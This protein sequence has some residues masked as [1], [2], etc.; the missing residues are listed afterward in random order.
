MATTYVPLATTTT[1]GNIATITLSSIS[2][3]Y[4]DLIL[5]G[6]G[7]NSAGGS[8][9]SIRFNGDTG[10]NYSWTDLEGDGSTAASYRQANTNLIYT[11][12]NNTSIGN[13]Q[14]NYI[15]QINNYSN[16]TTYKTVLS[17][18]NAASSNVYPGTNAGIGMWRNTNAITSITITSSGGYMVDGTTFSL[19]GIA[20]AGIIASAKATGGDIVATDGTYWYHAF[21][22]SGTFTPVAT[23][24]CDVLV[25]AGGASGSAEIGAGGGAGGVLE[26]LAQSIPASAQ[27]ITIGA[28]GASRTAAS[29]GQGNNGSNSSFASLTASVGGGGGGIANATAGSTGGSGGGGGANQSG[30]P[31]A[32]GA[33]TSG[34]GNAGGT[35]GYSTQGGLN[36]WTAGGGGGKGGTGGVGGAVNF[37]TGGAGGAGSNTWSSWVGIT[38]L[39]VSGFIA[40]GGGG[41]GMQQYGG[42]SNAPVAGPAGSGGGG[43]GAMANTYGGTS[44]LAGNGTANTG[45]GGGGGGWAQVAGG[46]ATAVS[47]QGGS[48]LVI[49]R[50]AV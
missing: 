29:S 8:G 16:T 22:A 4:T 28:G 25:V 17:R 10:N 3:A 9:W 31:Y 48:G 14:S 50:Y 18:T 46:T 30:G 13:S 34:Q 35:G 5:I 47:G 26:Y 7:R 41:I 2:S 12:Y 23:L 32:G 44:S 43:I 6:D 15:L 45:G 33:G 21:R 37:Y 20:S 36:Y 42:G 19:Y 40:G 39:G 27:T 38:G 1:S 24:S 11:S 49:V